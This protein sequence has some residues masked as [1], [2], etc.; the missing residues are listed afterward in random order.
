MARQT[1]T[2]IFIETATEEQWQELA[3]LIKAAPK[4]AEALPA[5]EKGFDFSYSSIAPALEERGLIERRKRTVL[6]T[7][8]PPRNPDGSQPFFVG[9]VPADVKKISRSVQLNEDIYARLQRLEA[10]KGQYTHSSILNQLL[11][12]AL[13]KYGY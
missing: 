12:D 1:K 6:N 13:K 3:E 10:D 4:K 7:S 11:D 2:Q 5:P 9:D 8:L